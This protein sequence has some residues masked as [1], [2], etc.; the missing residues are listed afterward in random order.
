[1]APKS[2]VR[3][4]PGFASVIPKIDDLGSSFYAVRPHKPTIQIRQRAI[5][6]VA[7]YSNQAVVRK[8]LN[9][10]PSACDRP[11][12]IE[13][14]AFRAEVDLRETPVA[15]GAQEARACI[16]IELPG[17]ERRRRLL[18]V[19]RPG[20]AGQILSQIDRFIICVDGKHSPVVLPE[21]DDEL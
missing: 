4:Q 18:V 14:E 12:S 16:R 15:K 20:Q 8:Q 7:G 6:R 9:F 1:M 19:K 17:I 21:I 5:G 13:A 11:N 3:P 10:I 2:P